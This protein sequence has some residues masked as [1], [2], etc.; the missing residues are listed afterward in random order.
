MHYAVDK[1]NLKIVRLLDEFG[2]DAR[3]QNNMK[4]SSID[5]AVKDDIKEIKMHFMSKAM[6]SG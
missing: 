5:L 6:Y 4:F 1:K 2:A 3:I